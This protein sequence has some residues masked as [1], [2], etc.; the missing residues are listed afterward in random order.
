AM[1]SS[2][3]PL[4]PSARRQHDPPLNYVD[5]NPLNAALLKQYPDA[6]DRIRELMTWYGSGAGPWSGFPGYEEIAEKLLLQYPNAELIKAVEGRTL[7]EAE[8]E[9]AA[10]I[11]GGWRPVPDATPIPADLRE[12]LLNHC[13]QSKDQGK[14][15]RAT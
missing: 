12:T 2:L 11:L 4:W 1:P 9:G 7:S 8:L 6:Y 10:R 14:I 15:H 13:L 5:M 3:K